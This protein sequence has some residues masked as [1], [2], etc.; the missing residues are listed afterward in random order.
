M[1]ALSHERKRLPSTPPQHLHP[2]LDQLKNL[3][4]GEGKALI[5]FETSQVVLT[6]R[7]LD[8]SCPGQLFLKVGPRELLN[9]LDSSFA[10]PTDPGTQIILGHEGHGV[11]WFAVLALTSLGLDTDSVTY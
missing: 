6:H 10:S 3:S 11:Q 2:T 8:N 4:L 1:N 7:Q 5:V 9:G